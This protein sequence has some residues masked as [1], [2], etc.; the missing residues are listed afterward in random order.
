MGIVVLILGVVLGIPLVALIVA[1]RA[2]VQA[3][4][5]A[6]GLQDAEKEL[7][8]LRFS[9]DVLKKRLFTLE[10]HHG[11]EGPPAEEA[12]GQPAAA[13][14]PAE[15]KPGAGP[16]VPPPIP[17][18][19]D[20]PVPPPA[21]S[22]A[23]PAGKTAVPEEIRAPAVSGSVPA[24]IIK[25]PSV[26]GASPEAPPECAG[27]GGGSGLPEEEPSEIGPGWER[28]LGILLPVWIGAIAIALGGAFLVKYSIDKGL[29]GPKARVAGAILLGLGLL[30]A[31][32][33]L[34]KKGTRMTAHGSSAAG[35]AVLYAAVLSAVNLYHL[36]SPWMG[37]VFLGVITA[38]GVFLSLRQGI[39]VAFVG[40]VGGFFTPY[41]I[42]VVSASPGR[43]FSYLLLLQAGLLVVSRKRRWT[44]M[45][46][47]TLVLGLGSVFHRMVRLSMPGDSFWVGVFLLVSAV[48]F[49][50]TGQTWK[51]SEEAEADFPLE[52][53]SWQNLLGYG[54]ILGA[55]AAL[56]VLAFE[57]RFNIQEWLFL[58]LLSAGMLVLGRTDR[59]YRLMPWVAFFASGLPAAV[60]AFHHPAGQLP[61]LYSVCA[62]FGVVFAAGGYIAHLRSQQPA[63]WATLSAAGGLSAF[64]MAY[65]ASRTSSSGHFHW[66]Y[67]S[68]LL[69]LVYTLPAVW[70]AMP[71]RRSA[72]GE[73][74]LAAF[75]VAVTSFA[76][77]AVPLELSNQWLTVAWALEVAAL[78]WLLQRLRVKVLGTLGLILSAG[79][80]ARLLLN[81]AV[82]RY[83]LGHLPVLNW[84]L[85]GYGLPALAFAAAAYFYKKA[86][87][88][89]SGEA[90]AWC[91][92]ALTFVLLT[93]EVRQGFHPG[94]LLGP[95]P[96]RV[97]WSTYS[98]VWLVAGLLILAAHRRWKTGLLRNIGIAFLGL[99]L[100]K[101]FMVDV[102][103]VNPVWNPSSV[104]PWPVWNWILYVYA[105]P[106]L[107]F[108]LAAYLLKRDDVFYVGPIFAW[109]AGFLGLVL[110][111]LEVRQSFHPGVLGRGG[112]TLTELAT[113]SHLWIA[114]GAVLLI[115]YQWRKAPILK[116]LGGAFLLAAALKVILLEV[117][118]ASPLLY[119]F[120]V[121]SLPVLNRLLYV[122][123][124]PMAV[125][126]GIALYY[127]RRNETAQARACSWFAGVLLF[128]LS[129]LEVR[130]FF[131]GSVLKG[132]WP[133]LV[134]WA[135]YPNAWLLIGI[136]LLLVYKKW[137]DR[138]F[139][140]LAWAFGGAGVILVAL[141]NVL[142]GSPLLIHHAVGSFP[143][144]NWLLY[145]YGAPLVL[146]AV[147]AYLAR[148][149][150]A[151]GVAAKIASYGGWLLA[152]L[153]ITLEVRQFF[154][155]RFLDAGRILQKENYWYSAVWI[156]FALFLLVVGIA[157]RGKGLRIASLVVVF[158]AV[159]KVFVY[160][161]RQLQDLYR[162]GSFLAL[163]VSLLVISFL[164]QRFVFAEAGQE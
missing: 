131:S 41:F 17:V 2:K 143:L 150:Q 80:A 63:H 22:P 129:T 61:L 6:Q 14:A 158:L 75:C 99:G 114:A 97:E 43:L 93:L 65:W 105:P 130:Q 123:A 50:W 10:M 81:P 77:L 104:G 138:T 27:A 164:Y 141:A 18:S 94:R 29:I 162:V 82:Y 73:A 35:I 112:C 132:K 51:T 20:R 118:A 57:T 52:G 133:G 46:A 19:Q 34:L 103:A 42:G 110:L 128:V 157:R 31:G 159:T 153:L 152:F 92:G 90:L 67:L 144:F 15:E 60:W 7:S 100:V 66:G 48:I 146:M 24:A 53:I 139:K 55:A 142:L 154:Q 71:A 23:Q 113:Y 64:L 78:A 156:L 49:L 16:V 115:F 86:D 163:G 56:A 124:L 1:I 79:V 9:L 44:G 111:A 116:K 13:V 136:F 11:P 62:G 137:N 98:H 45:A 87:W 91:S 122:Y 32:E 147:F 59:R 145:I 125:F 3:G 58:G 102:M 119:P 26:Q 96:G 25:S 121:G 151:E 109:S 120:H 127:A 126:A 12:G 40:L 85:Y 84:I 107:A 36:F 134:E 95:W 54:S 149:T 68:L 70:A 30:G 38:A 101:I 135:T 4:E 69:A 74:H 8:A 155:G 89:V 106:I 47:L 108:G 76:S 39:V 117:T 161:L 83:P 28:R 148:G 37:F 140:E 160:D 72:Y 33:W 88:T 21:I 5:A